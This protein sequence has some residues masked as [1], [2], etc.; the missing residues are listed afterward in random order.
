METY[1]L[2]WKQYIENYLN[3]LREEERSKLTIK[4]YARDIARF[5]AFSMDNWTNPLCWPGKRSLSRTAT[6]PNY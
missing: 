4:K 6:P 3:Y 1:D 2:L 5:L